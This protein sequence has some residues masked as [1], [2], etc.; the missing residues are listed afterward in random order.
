[1]IINNFQKYQKKDRLS[2][3]LRQKQIDR[4]I[5]D[6]PLNQLNVYWDIDVDVEGVAMW[7]VW[8]NAVGFWFNDQ[9]IDLS[10]IYVYKYY[11]QYILNNHNAINVFIKT[12]T[13]SNCKP[14]WPS[15]LTL[16]R[17]IQRERTL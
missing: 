11:S 15:T 2:T 9:E 16:S 3:N 5:Y 4:Q 17:L 10:E 8:Q 14:D 1:M 6:S 12:F 13:D 7:F